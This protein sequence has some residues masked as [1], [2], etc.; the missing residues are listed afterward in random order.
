MPHS[1]LPRSFEF[2]FDAVAAADFGIPGPPFPGSV[3][4]DTVGAET[5]RFFDPSPFDV[6]G[7]STLPGFFSAAPVH[8]FLGQVSL[9]VGL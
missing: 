7:P 9:L 5:T 3:N 8:T 2:D 4:P 1:V 6:A